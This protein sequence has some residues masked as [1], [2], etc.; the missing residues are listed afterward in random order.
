[1]T[2]AYQM[3]R[4][5]ARFA[6]T[7]AE[8]KACQA[9]R[10][11]CFFGSDGFDCDQFDAAAR[12][13][14]VQDAHGR[15]VAT[16]RLFDWADGPSAQAGY[17]AQF[18][19]L[20]ALSGCQS[21]MVELGRVCVAPEVMDADVLRTVWGALTGHVD[22]TRATM[23]FGCTSFAGVDP[24]PYG[25]ALARLQRRHLGPAHLRPARLLPNC[26]RFAD[27]PSLGRQPMP[28]LLRTYLAMGGWVSDHAV[29]DEQMQTLHVFT[30]LEVAKVP[31]ARARALRAL[32]PATALP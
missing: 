26:I 25:Q 4:Y 28:P 24:V 17:A 29:I 23:L 10:Q 20:S 16:A 1:M 19:D 21:P 13:L 18:Y 11:R 15:C 6:H 30:C 3:G 22:R 2:F 27:V 12:H 31:H 8:V 7:A 32:A 14:I 5:L 9:L